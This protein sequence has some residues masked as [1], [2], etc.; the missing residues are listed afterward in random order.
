M[1]D[2]ISEGLNY[3]AINIGPLARLTDHTF[4]HPKFGTKNEGRIFVGEHLRSTG[5]EISFRDLPAKTTITF[6]HKHRTHEEIYIILKGSGQYQVDEDIFR[7][8]EGSVI[9]VSPDGSRT[10][11][12]DS[13]ESMI[14]MVVQAAAETL[15]GYDVSDGYRVEGEINIPK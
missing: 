15:K 3:K 2:L 14:Y 11:C 1:I 6:L 9:R 10:L 7:I 8:G 12:N 13:G 4:I 5:S